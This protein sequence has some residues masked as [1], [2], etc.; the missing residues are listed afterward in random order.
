MKG[1]DTT[2]LDLDD[3][4]SSHHSI[5]PRNNDC[6]FHQSGHSTSQLIY[7]H[8]PLMTHSDEEQKKF[9]YRSYGFNPLSS[10]TCLNRNTSRSR[11]F[12]FDSESWIPC[13]QL[14]KSASPL[15]RPTAAITSGSHNSSESKSIITRILG[16][17]FA[18]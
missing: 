15:S 7:G 8:K 5:A 2:R 6:V 16:I 3:L 13:R 11:S 12:Q 17:A 14:R 4:R 18:A 9:S 1:T 10:A